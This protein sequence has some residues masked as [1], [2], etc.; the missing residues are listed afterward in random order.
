MYCSPE[1]V[2]VWQYR[3]PDGGMLVAV[4]PFDVLLYKVILG[5]KS[6]NIPQIK[7]GFGEKA[8]EKFIATLPAD[9]NVISSIDKQFFPMADWIATRFSDFAHMPQRSLKDL[10]RLLRIARGEC[11][12]C[13]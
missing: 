8:L 10:R 2:A 9:A 1:S 13:S 5:D 7:K 4:K 6:D 12:L 11:F 3:V